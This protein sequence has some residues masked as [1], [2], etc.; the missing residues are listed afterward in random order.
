MAQHE[1]A[2]RSDRDRREYM[3][4]WVANYELS[5]CLVAHAEAGGSDAAAAA[6]ISDRVHFLRFNQVRVRGRERQLSVLGS[7]LSCVTHSLRI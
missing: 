7:V 1:A 3:R 6:E 5:D 2:F 4:N